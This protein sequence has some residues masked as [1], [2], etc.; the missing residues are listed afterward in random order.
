MA[1]ASTAANGTDCAW[2]SP[3]ILL[4]VIA[5]GAA[6]IALVLPAHQVAGDDLGLLQVAALSL[7][8]A[9]CIVGTLWVSSGASHIPRPRRRSWPNFL[10]AARACDLGLLPFVS[11]V[12]RICHLIAGPET[13][14]AASRTT[15]SAIV[16]DLL[17]D[18]WEDGGAVI[19]VHE[20]YS[21]EGMASPLAAAGPLL[22]IPFRDILIGPATV[23][24]FELGSGG[25]FDG[26]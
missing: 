24:A 19:K 14:A 5:I 25:A 12:D 6:T 13:T 22:F 11:Q 8:V 4:G 15:H 23:S 3:S 21:A 2:Q 18:H 1:A 9:V 26:E 20:A 10:N 17:R 16:R 7:A